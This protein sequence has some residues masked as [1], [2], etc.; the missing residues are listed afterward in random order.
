[1][2]EPHLSNVLDGTIHALQEN[3]PQMIS[4]AEGEIDL[5]PWERWAEAAYISDS[6]TEVNLMSLMRD[7]LGHASVPGVFGRGLMDKYPDLLHDIYDMDAGFIY[8]LIGLPQ[9][10][11]WPS[12]NRAHRARQR[13]WRA[14]DEQQRA[15]DSMVDGKPYNST[16]GD[17][18]DVSEFILKRHALFKGKNTQ[19][20]E[21]ELMLTHR[22]RRI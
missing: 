4:F 6:E 8:F 19:H 20:L 10:T 3:I 16:W 9:W 18:D 22:R 2:K 12:V 14:L 17:L 1:M 5:Q 15:L 13:A 11:P 7:M 21:S